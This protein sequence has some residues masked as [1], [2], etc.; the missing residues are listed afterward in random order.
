MRLGLVL[1]SVCSVLAGCG[2]SVT[3]QLS[4]ASEEQAVDSDSKNAAKVIDACTQ[5]A[6]GS[7]AADAFVDNNLQH[8]TFFR[9][10][11][12][13]GI[14]DG[15][16]TY[17]VTTSND[18][19]GDTERTV[20]VQEHGSSCTVSSV[21]P[22]DG[23]KIPSA[24]SARSA[25]QAV[26]DTCTMVAI[27][28]AAKKALLENNLQ[29]LHR[30]SLDDGDP[31]QEGTLKYSVTLGNEED[32]DTVYAVAVKQAINFSTGRSSCTVQSVSAAH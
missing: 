8:L 25:Y 10:D 29:H 16:L 1:L 2:S 24:S 15:K 11:G 9:V 7:A 23:A 32:G 31:A 30:L 3:S 18:E 5:A 27:D 13:P 20:V 12:A 6:I 26:I 19:D 28:R 17:N 4:G 21:K 14:T 22:L